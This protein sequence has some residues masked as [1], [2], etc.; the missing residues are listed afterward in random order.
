MLNIDV[1]APVRWEVSPRSGVVLNRVSGT[2][3]IGR[4][5]KDGTVYTISARLMNRSDIKPKKLYV[6]TRAGNPFAGYWRESGGDIRELVFS[7][8]GTFSLTVHPFEV[9]KDYWGRYSYDLRKQSISFFIHGGNKKPEDA[10][11]NGFFRFD[12]AGDLVLDSIYFGTLFPGN[13]MKRS[14]T[15]K[16]Y[17]G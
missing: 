4:K 1:D 17:A 2:L 10:D 6:Y 3:V 12:N 14:Y 11:L 9:Y 7:P 13:A 15:F 8:D 5:V 16:K